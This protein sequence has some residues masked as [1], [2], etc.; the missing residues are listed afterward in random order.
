MHL[1]FPSAAE[2][3]WFPCV[4]SLKF[5]LSYVIILFMF[6]IIMDQTKSAPPGDHQD[7]KKCYIN[8]ILVF[9]CEPKSKQQCIKDIKGIQW[10][11]EYFDPVL[12]STWQRGPT[13]PLFLAPVLCISRAVSVGFRT[14]HGGPIRAR[15][16][17]AASRC[18]AVVLRAVP[19]CPAARVSSA[20]E[21]SSFT[22]VFNSF[23]APRWHTFIHFERHISCVCSCLFP[24]CS[25]FVCVCAVFV[26]I[27]CS[28]AELTSQLCTG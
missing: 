12:K 18:Y 4:G 1:F 14:L 9:K 10:G 11:K 15:P 27:R 8:F 2:T 13:L 17:A 21:S 28:P 24:G 7:K 26:D 20:A 22:A 23:N 25:Y 3:L 6:I 19:S 5:I 16:P